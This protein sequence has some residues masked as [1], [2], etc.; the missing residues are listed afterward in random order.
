MDGIDTLLDVEHCSLSKSDSV[1]S[2]DGRMIGMAVVV[3]SKGFEMTF[4]SWLRHKGGKKQGDFI[5]FQ[6]CLFVNNHVLCLWDCVLDY[7][8]FLSHIR[9]SPMN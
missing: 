3:G 2:E 9:Q 6:S 8:A 4:V 1:G 5:L 7:D